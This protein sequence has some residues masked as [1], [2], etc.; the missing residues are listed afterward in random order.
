M[1]ANL[2]RVR[3]T[4]AAKGR[5]GES[6]LNLTEAAGE[7]GGVGVGAGRAS[8]RWAEKF[9]Q[10]KSA[11]V[12]R[13]TE[14]GTGDGGLALQPAD[15]CFLPE[16]VRWLGCRRQRIKGPASCYTELYPT[17]KALWHN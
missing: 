14:S 15:R 6:R 4:R 12:G 16:C 8:G 9:G 1:R 5:G 3:V 11:D 13:E 2:W 17:C 7:G 10:S